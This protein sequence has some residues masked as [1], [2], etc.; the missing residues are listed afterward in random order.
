MKNIAVLSLKSMRNRKGTVSLT[1]ISIA[2]SVTLLLGVERIRSESHTNFT[3]T[4]SGTDL[5]VGARSGPIQLLLYSVFRIG[6]ATSNFSWETCNHLSKL[7]SVEWLVPLSLGDSHKGYRVLGTTPLYFSRFSYGNRQ[8]LEFSAGNP[9][10]ELYDAVLGAEVAAKLGYLIDD[11]IILSHGAGEV[12]FIEHSDKPFR[13]AGILKATGTPV[14]RTVHVSL[15]GIEALHIDWQGGVPFPGRTISPQQ[16]RR[17]DLTP[18]TV[19][20]ALVKLKTPIATFKVQRYVNTYQP[21]PLTAILP[22]TA[23]QQL[24][25]L[26]GVAGKA[27]MVISAFVVVVGLFG[28]LTALL[29]SL[30]ERRREMAILRSVG[31]RPIHI[32]SLIIGEALVVTSAGITVGLMLLFG[33]LGSFQSLLVTRFGLHMTVGTLSVTE[34]V[35]VTCVWLA[36]IVIGAIPAWRIY[37]YSLA[38]GMTIRI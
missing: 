27:L 5:V 22:G 29:T 11:P 18:K 38:D 2:L 20:A 19:T 4:I 8:Q 7:P 37:H 10:D 28:M 17:L 26:I 6:H 25:Q 33:L 15:E 1:I 34:A 9:F 14:D 12:S 13:V 32:F 31:A 21:E 24:W 23:L 36:G 16:A 35:L 30:N 3:N